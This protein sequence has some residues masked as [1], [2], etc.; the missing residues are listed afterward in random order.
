M[1]KNKAFKGN[2]QAGENL[3]DAGPTSWQPSFALAKKASPFSRGLFNFSGI[4][5]GIEIL[6]FP[7]ADSVELDDCLSFGPNEMFHASGP[8]TEGSRRHCLCHR[9]IEFVAHAEIKSAGD[10]GNVLDGGMDV[11]G[12]FITIR[13]RNPHGKEAF[14]GGIALEHSHFRSR[15]QRWGT[16]LPL[17][18]VGGMN[19]LPVRWRG[20]C[21]VILLRGNRSKE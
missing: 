6:N 15:R 11:R 14:F 19:R 3:P 4:V 2:F 1:Q 18:L 12:N 13:Q 21:F 8:E 10:D 17:D 20:S 7:R 5:G 9:L 16:W